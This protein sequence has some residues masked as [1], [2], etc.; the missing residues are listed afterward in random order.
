MSSCSYYIWYE[1]WK[2]LVQFNSRFSSWAW[3]FPCCEMENNPEKSHK[4]WKV[5]W[6]KTMKA[7]KRVWR[8]WEDDVKN[9]KEKNLSCVIFNLIPF[10]ISILIILTFSALVAMSKEATKE[11]RFSFHIEIAWNLQTL[12]QKIKKERKSESSIWKDKITV[13]SQVIY[14]WSD[15]NVKYR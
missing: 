5:R 2:P 4:C 14:F 12:K 9:Y 7:E 13:H 15:V 1:T 10:S 11:N 8:C 6:H 3:G